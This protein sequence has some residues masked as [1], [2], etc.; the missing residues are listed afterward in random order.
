MDFSEF[1]LQQILVLNGNVDKCVKNV[2]CFESQMFSQ[3]W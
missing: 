3:L 1:I 2:Y